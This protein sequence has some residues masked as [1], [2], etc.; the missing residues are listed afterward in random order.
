MDCRYLDELYELFLLGL[1]KPQEAGE[2]Q[3]HLER[4]CPYCLHHLGEA[5]Q[6][7]YFLL[8]SPKPRKP[9]PGVKA[10]LLRRVRG[11]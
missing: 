9:A 5:A 7:V 10:E 3:E 8:S 2:I 4:A 6:S 11:K 1:L